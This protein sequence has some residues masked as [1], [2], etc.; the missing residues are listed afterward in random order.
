MHSHSETCMWTRRCLLSCTQMCR[1]GEGTLA[2]GGTLHLPCMDL[3]AG[4]TYFA[5]KLQNES[6]HTITV[7]INI[8]CS[9]NTVVSVQLSQMVNSCLLVFSVVIRSLCLNRKTNK[10]FLMLLPCEQPLITLLRPESTRLTPTCT[11]SLYD[12]QLGHFIALSIHNNFTSAG[13]DICFDTT[14]L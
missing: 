8:T 4:K 1:A 11:C 5:L 12:E 14:S 2:G 7:Y 10:D 13:I 6:S 3:S 9:L